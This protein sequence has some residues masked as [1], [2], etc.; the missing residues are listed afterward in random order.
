[1]ALRDRRFPS[2]K[3]LGDKQQAVAVELYRQEKHAI[4]EICKAVGISRPTLWKYVAAAG[5]R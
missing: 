3:K 5:N 4:D 1:L 2:R